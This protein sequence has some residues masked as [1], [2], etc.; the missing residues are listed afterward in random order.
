MPA[1]ADEVAQAESEGMELLSGW[2]PK[3][4]LTDEAGQ[5]CGVSLIKCTR[6]LDELGRFSPLYD[7]NQTLEIEC[8][9]VLVAVGQTILWNELLKG[10]NVEFN[11]DGTVKAD[12]LTYQT[13]EPDIFVGGDVFTGPSFV[14]DAIAAGKEG[15]ISLHRQ[16]HEGQSL[17]F[18]RDRRVYRALDRNN[19][20]ISLGSFDSGARQVPGYNAAK[21]KSFGDTRVTF[22]EEQ[23]RHETAR[24]LGCGSTKVDEYMCIGCGQCTTKCSFDAIRMEKKYDVFA[25]NFEK[26]PFSVAKHVVK[27]GVTIAT[28]PLRG[29]R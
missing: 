10:S 21:A 2:G 15:A 22:T 4:I 29:G 16:V 8:E 13:A 19:T 17:T 3:E 1:A 18:G 5:V 11:K 14:I 27:R 26:L 24:C 28:K 25:T 7:E 6:V 20:L 12:P 9:N 23:L